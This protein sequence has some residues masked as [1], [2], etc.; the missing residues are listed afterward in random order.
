MKHLFRVLVIAILLTSK[1]FA[2]SDPVRVELDHIFQYIDKSQVPSGY[3]D[4]FGPQFA[5]KKWYTGV[6]TDSNFIQFISGFRFLYN[7]IEQSRIYSGAPLL[8]S[9]DVV[10][11]SI[12]QLPVSNNTPLIFLIAKYATAKEDAI[13]LNLFSNNGNNQILDVPGRTQSPYIE[14][15]FF[16]ACP[17]KE[18]APQKNMISLSYNPTLAFSNCGKTISN[19]AVDFLKGVGYVTIA[20]NSSVSNIYTDSSGYKKFIIK[21]SCTDGSIYYCYSQ[22]FVTVTG[23]NSNIGARYASFTDVEIANPAITIP[24]VSGEHY[25]AKVYIRYSKKRQGTPLSNKL[26]KPFIIVEGYDLH[27]AA[28]SLGR[29]SNYDINSLLLE[30]NNLA[31]STPGYDL[32]QQLDDEAGYDLVFVDYYTMDYIENNAKMLEKVIDQINIIKVNNEVGVREKNVVMG[33][34]LGGVLSR[35]TLAKMTKNRGTNS[36][37]TRLYISYDS[38][39]Q[40]GNVPIGFQHFLQDFGELQILGRKLKDN[41]DQLKEFYNLNNQPATSQLLLLQV[42]NGTGTV[43]NNSFFAP[44]G[45]YRTMVDFTPSQLISTPPLYEF[46]AISQ[47]SQC[48][49]WVMQP[50]TLLT[51]FNENISNGRILLMGIYLVKYRLAIQ[52][53]SLPA[54]GSFGQVSYVRMQRNIKYFYGVIGTGWKTT[55]EFTRN[56]SGSTIPWDG[57]PGGTSSA[58]GRSGGKFGGGSTI[59]NI[60]NGN[61]FVGNVLRVLLYGLFFNINT[62]INIPFQQDFFTTVP[63]NSS[64]DL[65]NVSLATFNQSYIYPINGLSGSRAKTYIANEKFI[66]SVNSQ[67]AILY[68]YE[69]A[70]FT[71]RQSEWMF[72]EMENKVNNIACTQIDDCYAPTIQLNS[73]QSSCNETTISSSITNGISYSWEVSGDLLINGT[74]TNLTTTASNINVTGTW[75]NVYVYVTLGCGSISGSLDYSPFN[76]EIQGLYP[77]YI[78]GDHV[79][80]SVNT[81]QYDL[82]YKWYVNNILV[83]EGPYATSYCTCNYETPEP[84]QCGENSIKVE[85]ETSCGTTA[86]ENNFT[87]VCGYGMMSNVTMYPNPASDQVTLSLSQINDSKFSTKL[88]DIKEVKILNKYGNMKKTQKFPSNSQKITLNIS[89]LPL[90]IYFIEISDGKNKVI[91]KLSLQ[92]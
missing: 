84:R 80:V 81:T 31:Q 57:V 91:L 46:K 34:S 40:G 35:Y 60:N 77:E 50:G 65:Q 28:P 86:A 62:N 30:W 27:D 26:V 78:P 2:Q 92:K 14:N 33:I 18:D 74:S 29:K 85:V 67:P 55:D 47:G 76:R 39:H 66:G 11:N 9:L 1:V 69:H 24:A 15:N 82:N 20:P 71:K 10:N 89:N 5:E 54:Q 63:I 37:D 49:R 56:T 7:D 44:G 59:P 72:N 22:Q 87:M 42:L 19:V 58:T 43:V 51:Q 45:P 25:G 41:V 21:V 79:S 32:S 6:L 75:G 16:A 68:N 4:E 8:T 12:N 53:N 17:V 36:T 64:L 90:D 48:S 88:Q 52:V 83:K 73:S 13:N 61:T 3:L 38:P 23:L 70:D